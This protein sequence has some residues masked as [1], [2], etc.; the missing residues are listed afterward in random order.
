VSE[1]RTEALKGL[2]QPVAVVAVDWR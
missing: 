1:P 2:E